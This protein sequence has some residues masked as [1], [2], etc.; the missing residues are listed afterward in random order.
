[1]NDLSSALGLEPFKLLDYQ[2]GAV[3]PANS[4]LDTILTI[5]VGIA[6]LVIAIGGW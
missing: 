6:V 2:G 1:M 4:P 3:F 5:I